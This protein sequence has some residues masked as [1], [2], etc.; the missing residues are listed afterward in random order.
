MTVI[1]I[2]GCMTGLS[3]QH[4]TSPDYS[5]MDDPITMVS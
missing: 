2:K 5:M 3:V 4:E 1:T